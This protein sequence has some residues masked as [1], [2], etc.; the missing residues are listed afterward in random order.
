MVVNNS[1][2]TNPTDGTCDGTTAAINPLLAVEA[3]L[4]L[5]AEFAAGLFLFLI[6]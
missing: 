3:G 2:R 6:A 4:P 1:K 5:A